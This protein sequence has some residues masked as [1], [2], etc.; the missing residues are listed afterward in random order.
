[1]VLI[2]ALAYWGFRNVI[3]RGLRLRLNT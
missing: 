1:V 3:G 2:G